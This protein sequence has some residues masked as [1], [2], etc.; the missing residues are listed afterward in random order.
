MDSHDLDSDAVPVDDLE[1]A[2]TLLSKKWSVSVLRVL[3]R[4]GPLGFSALKQ[5]LDGVSGKVLTDCLDAL[6]EGDLVERRVIQQEP[7]RV[8]YS[9]TA[10]GADLEALIEDLETWTHTHLV[11]DIPTV[12][13]VEDDDRKVQ[14]HERWLSAYDVQTTTSGA[15]ARDALDEQVDVVVTDRRLPG[16]TGEKLAQ[17]VSLREVDCAVVFLSSMPLDAQLLDVPFDDYVR[18]PSSPEE[19]RTAVENGLSLLELDAE[20]RTIASIERRLSLFD[21]ELSL[22][23]R[24]HDERYQRLRKRVGRSEADEPEAQT[25]LREEAHERLV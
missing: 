21:A 8:E 15:D 11:S 13:L 6:Q 3:L 23:M 1:S 14:L 22:E 10:K 4:D 24:T 17:T 19:L 18:K 12:L 5:R 2:V 9:L 16:V 7:L 25:A 20:Q